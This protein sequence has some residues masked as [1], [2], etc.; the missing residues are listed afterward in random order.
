MQTNI[1]D[2]SIDVAI[3]SKSL[4]SLFESSVELYPNKIAIFHN[5]QFITYRDLN[6]QVN[7]VA[8]QLI[9]LGVC[10]SI[11][12]NILMERSIDLIVGIL[13]V[14]KAGAAYTII[15]PSYPINRIKY[16]LN[17]TH[18]SLLLTNESYKYETKY[19]NLLAL[20]NS[21]ELQ[22]IYLS[23]LL[24]DADL[25]LFTENPILQSTGDS[26]ACVIYTSG[27][28][29]NPK[30]VL[31]EHK[32]FFRLFNGPN[33][34]QTTNEDRIAQMASASFDMAIYEM[35]A[36]LGKGGSLVIIDKNVV[37][38]AEALEKSFKKYGITTAWLT[39]G[40][41][42]Q[43]I[44]TRPEIFKGFKSV[45]FG[46]E[47]ANFEI[48]RKIL[49]NKEIKPQK[50][51]NS[52]GPTECGCFTTYYELKTL[53]DNA[54]SVPIGFPVNDTQVYVLDEDFNK[55]KV[56]EVGEL[57]ITGDGVA[58]GYLNLPELT[59]DKFMLCPFDPNT[60]MYATGDLVRILPDGALDFVGRK[61][62]QVKIRGHRIEL[63][64]IECALETHPEIWKA[65]V[66]APYT[67]QGHRQ[68]VAY[69]V[70]KNNE[71]IGLECIKAHLK[72]ILPNYMI[73]GIIMPLDVFPLN[74]NGKIDRKKLAEISINEE[75][76]SAVEIIDLNENEKSLL[77]IWKNVLGIKNIKLDDNFFD[78]GGDSMMIMQIIS[79][80]AENKITLSYSLIL[81]YPT[82]QSLS[83]LI[84]DQK[85]KKDQ[86]INI[87]DEPLNP[88]IKEVQNNTIS[89]S[90]TQYNLEEFSTLLPNIKDVQ[91]ICPLSSMQEGL[92]F[93]AI[94][95]SKSHAYF[96][97]AYWRSKGTY[98][99]KAMLKAWDALVSNHDL[100]RTSYLWEGLPH[101]IQIIYKK[102]TITLD[103]QDWRTLLPKEQ[104]ARLHDYWKKDMDLGI[105]LTTSPLLRIVIIQTSDDEQLIIWSFHHIIMDGP[106]LCKIIDE[107]DYYYSSLCSDQNF[108][109]KKV[110]SYKDYILWQKNQNFDVSKLFWKKYLNE[111][112]SPNQLSISTLPNSHVLI[113]GNPHI[114]FDR[115]LSEELSRLLNQYAKDNRLTLNTVM[116]G[117]WAYLLSI[118]CNTLDV[119][120]G[121][122][123]STRPGEI[124]NVH[125]IVG[126]LINIVP[127]RVIIDK[128]TSV[129]KYFETLQN[130]LAYVIDHSF[131]P[132]IDI[133]KESEFTS[134]HIFN[135]S[136][137]FESQQ[138]KELEKKLSSFYDI[139]FNAMTHY[140]LSIYITPEKCIEL[141]I[142]FNQN[143]Y[144][145]SN[146][147]QLI[148]HY[149][150]LLSN[151]TQT[152]D[153]P[154]KQLS[155]L[156]PQ[157][158]NKII[159]DWNQTDLLLPEN[160]LFIN[161]FEK[162]AQDN[163]KT[164]AIIYNNESISYEELNKQ[165][166]QLAHRLQ[167]LSIKTN[168]LVCICLDRTPA[169]LIAILGVLKAGSAYIP[170]DPDYPSDR[171]NYT[172][173]DSKAA[174]LITSAK[175]DQRIH[176]SGVKK[177]I[178]DSEWDIISENSTDNLKHEIKA[179]DL[180]YV[181]Y[182]SGSTGK[183]KGVMVHHLGFFNYLY[184]ATEIYGAD[185]KCNAPVQSSFAFDAT[186]TS[187]FLPL[188]T[189]GT[190]TLIPQE[191]EIDELYK[192]LRSKKHYHLIKI[193]PAHLDALAD[194]F[195]ANEVS[196][197]NI[198]VFVI[199]GEALNEKTLER[200]RIKAPKA[201]FFNEYGPTE[202]VVGCSVYDA[203]ASNPQRTSVPIGR[204]IG[205]TKLYV[206]NEYMQPVPQ[207]VIGELYI[208]GLGV[209]N[210]YLNKPDLTNEKFITDKFSTYPDAKLF[211]TGDLVRFQED[212]MLEFLGRKDNQVKIRGFR[213]ELQEIESVLLQ[214]SPIKEAAV[215]VYKD[216][217]E[218]SHMAAYIVPQN[219]QELDTDNIR[220]HLT[221]S[222][223]QYMLPTYYITLNKLPLTING[224]VD[225]KKLPA[226]TEFPLNK[227]SITPRNAQEQKITDIWAKVLK[228]ST[229]IEINDNFFDQGGDSLSAIRLISQIRKEFGIEISV[230]S[231]FD[232]PTIMELS[233]L[234]TKHSDI[235][236]IITSNTDS[237]GPSFI[238]PLQTM[239]N[240]QP[241]FL[242][243]PIGGT[244]FCYMGLKHYIN[245]RP[246][247]GI[248]DPG[249]NTSA[250]HF[251]SL[252]ELA[253]YYIKG[254]KQIQPKGPYFI[255]GAS[256]GGLIS[257]EIANQ[258]SAIGEPIEFIG[259]FDSWALYPH[260]TN[261]KDWFEKH[262]QEQHI[263]MNNQLIKAGLNPKNPWLNLQWNR[264]ELSLKYNLPIIKNKVTLFKA[265]ILL[266]ILNSYKSPT[267]LWEPYC[268]NLEVHLVPGDHYS[269]F[270]KQNIEKLG[271]C[272]S[273]HLS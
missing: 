89:T 2:Q 43:L 79:E 133:K 221:K 169:M 167:K 50:F 240:K 67:Q 93:H 17:D 264:K 144:S 189:G 263:Q 146:I 186:I 119:V 272:L 129:L 53:D 214:Y 200:W 250:P 58:R 130:N 171:L 68:L 105:D 22:S 46:G 123:V 85:N 174:V 159:K 37:L 142:N 216:S 213:I 14:L 41:F 204:P 19:K 64:E 100:L 59:A 78:L 177:I 153:I 229:P 188:F 139:K 155:C 69:F 249:I 157:E 45:A 80:L 235:Y 228:K 176:T 24:A 42:N 33:I 187:L 191:N 27:S 182:T 101:P 47:V 225:R 90:L 231:I 34:V 181:I 226:P 218:N 70:S 127:F 86:Q 57:Y 94:H 185:K 252:E 203:T 6:N 121:L 211:K 262:M 61:D 202:T 220:N 108:T 236:S 48:V 88:I 180:A 254:I 160:T 246:I 270:N 77:K 35:W 38:S 36:A 223:P 147:D 195:E 1:I 23:E 233:E 56:G 217:F 196:I 52:Y 192:L 112:T 178:I 265:E 107:L 63:E 259:L 18:T 109:L 244:V 102:A 242:I 29:G 166:N 209:A 62:N 227:V 124:K 267:N 3:S 232:A 210:G 164:T 256:L 21:F 32:A 82:I 13:G 143:L 238:I 151:L 8:L 122:T 175:Y 51:F 234:L 126:P 115:Y 163:S 49:N 165:A 44:K 128:D 208:G 71:K 198:D 54:T 245:D 190:V 111:F 92:L 241:L 117:M 172:I 268:N 173:E 116:Q 271:T 201:K 12:V 7:A 148:N 162:Q 11:I 60:T 98:N 113:E 255:G 215:C 161:V 135:S 149:I 125:S 39:T 103:E 179:K 134:N 84:E 154:L 158:F 183:P 138:R 110:S 140:P 65:V 91:A 104:K 25:S 205:N 40:L 95:D 257:L 10:E 212:G 141:K 269:M 230:R 81:Q 76:T 74:S 4:I 224:K 156:N 207:N 260:M 247:Y 132:Y 197:N 168:D 152:N 136:F 20:T 16:I 114:Q 75:T 106:S 239:G 222:L 96:I 145:Q 131:C 31:L 206:L 237:T 261:Q 97:Q 99:S 30:G 248:E 193:T 199:G 15:D 9:K 184:S 273:K 72:K 243:H 26:L 251:N 194:L 219:G 83:A 266:D 5:D 150:N 55:V 170:L 28:T 66:L 253:T 73:P 137:C 258:L 120:F 87:S 118:Y